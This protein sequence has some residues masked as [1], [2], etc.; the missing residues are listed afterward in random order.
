MKRTI[1]ILSLALTC[2]YLP[3]IAQKARVGIVAGVTM[4]NLTGETDGVNTNFD[5]RAGFTT[6]LIV[7]VPIGKTRFTFQPGVHYVQKGAV[8]SET[9]DQ[10]D[11]VALRY[12]EFAFHFLYNTKG[13]KGVNIF[14]GVGPSVSLN[15]PSKTV[16]KFQ[17]DGTKVE[18]NVIFGDE[19]AA[20]Y[21][22]I[23][24]GASGIA[25]LNF[26]NGAMLSFNYN[27][28]IRNLTPGKNSENSIR[29]SCFIVRLGLLIKNK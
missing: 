27:H 21:N 9:K 24:W 19:G 28:G 2:F 18:Q 20:Q 10:K 7:D 29:N 16:V 12:A 4:S 5:S 13:T 26:R 6:G 15:L 11:Y 3:A 25:G 23:D 14:A 17:D 22:G 1:L 8:I